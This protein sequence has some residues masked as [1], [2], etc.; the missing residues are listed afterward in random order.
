MAADELPAWVGVLLV[1]VLF[2]LACVVIYL[3]HK[4]R[5]KQQEESDSDWLDRQW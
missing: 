2:V 3:G 1:V 4:P 5:E